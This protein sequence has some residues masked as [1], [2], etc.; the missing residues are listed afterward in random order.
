MDRRAFGIGGSRMRKPERRPARRLGAEMRELRQ[1]LLALGLER[2]D[3]HIERRAA[4]QRRALGA[5]LV[6]KHPRKIADRANPDSR[7]ARLAAQ[8]LSESGIE[9]RP[10]RFRQR[11][12]RKARA[13]AQRRDGRDIKPA[14]A[15]QHA[16]QH[17]ARA[18]LAH[19]PARTTLCGAARRRRGRQCAARS[20]EP[21]KRC[22]RPQSL[23][24]S[25]AGRRRASISAK[26]SMAAE[27]EPPA[28]FRDFRRTL[29][30]WRRHAITFSS[31]RFSWP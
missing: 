15:L 19:E 9:R 29:Q 1:H 30:H 28:S 13:A 10:L 20:D 16:E 24:A 6:A 2:V 3:A 8:Q 14:L 31:L 27:S 25:A 17:R 7:P 11:R 22:D 21:A 26:T 18:R 23:S 4:R 12:R 5:A